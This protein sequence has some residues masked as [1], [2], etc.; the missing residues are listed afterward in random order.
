MLAKHKSQKEWLD[1]SQGMNTYLTTMKDMCAEVGKLSGK[2]N[3]AEN[4]IKHSHIGFCDQDSD[5]LAKLL[6]GTD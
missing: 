6:I 1:V 2:F 5:P 4:W 3:Y